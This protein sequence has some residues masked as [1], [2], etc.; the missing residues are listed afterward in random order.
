MHYRIH[1]CFL[2]LLAFSVQVSITASLL[3]KSLPGQMTDY[4][5]QTGPVIWWNK[6]VQSKISSKYHESYGFIDELASDR[7]KKV[8]QE[9]Q[10]A[11]SIPSDRWVPLKKMSSTGYMAA[12]KGSYAA[13][14]PTATYIDENEF[15][16]LSTGGI[17]CTLFHEAVHIKYNHTAMGTIIRNCLFWSSGLGAFLVMNKLFKRQ[18]NDYFHLLGKLVCAYGVGYSFANSRLG[19]VKESCKERDADIEGYYATGCYQCVQ[20]LIIDN[21]RQQIELEKD[22]TILAHRRAINMESETKGYLTPD[23][24]E[25]IIEDLKMENKVCPVHTKQEVEMPRE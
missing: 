4:I 20:E 23:E 13:A 17:R 6:D 18:S 7:Y 25:K 19:S 21:D 16:N 22:Q 5:S 2:I 9:A 12:L 1:V 15:D 8:W 10:T 3:Q 24:L 11:L 14:E